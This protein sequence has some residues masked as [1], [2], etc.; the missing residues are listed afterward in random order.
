VLVPRKFAKSLEEKANANDVPVN[1]PNP[2]AQEESKTL[3]PTQ[4]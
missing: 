1:G 3:H 4:G 2:T